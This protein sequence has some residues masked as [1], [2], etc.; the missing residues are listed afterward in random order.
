MLRYL[1]LL[2]VMAIGCTRAPITVDLP[3]S[4]I[5]CPQC[6]DC[7]EA[8]KTPDACRGWWPR[9]SQ[10]CCSGSSESESTAGAKAGKPS[11]K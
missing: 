9:V 8:K 7:H 2:A 3:A 1:C 6:I 10:R 4:F 5:G 11:V